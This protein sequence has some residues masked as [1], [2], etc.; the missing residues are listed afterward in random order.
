M[1]V[2]RR[3]RTRRVRR[4]VLSATEATGVRCWLLRLACACGVPR[5][6]CVSVSSCVRV[7]CRV[8]AGGL[9]ALCAFVC[10][11]SVQPLQEPPETA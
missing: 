1:M 7:G 3:R 9:C 10:E 6:V 5:G 4:G 11:W 2:G 8:C